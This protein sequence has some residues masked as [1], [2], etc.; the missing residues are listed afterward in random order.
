M[1][2]AQKISAPKFC[3][4]ADNL[5]RFQKKFQSIWV[6]EELWEEGTTLVRVVRL[7]TLPFSHFVPHS[8][9]TP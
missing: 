4:V 6:A 8:N 7:Q 3:F 2:D 1:K 9:S 5:V